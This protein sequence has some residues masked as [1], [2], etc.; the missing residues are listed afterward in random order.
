MLAAIVDIDALWTILL[1][2][3]L[4][5]VGLTALFGEGIGALTR[6]ADA[7]RRQD[8]A[9]IAGNATLVALTTVVCLAALAIGFVA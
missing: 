3:L 7:R 4:V 9:A 8:T 6:L 1:A 5:G 2:A